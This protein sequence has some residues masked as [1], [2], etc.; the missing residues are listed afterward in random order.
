MDP[1]GSTHCNFLSVSMTDLGR[2][3]QGRRL[4]D[5]AVIDKSLYSMGAGFYTCNQNMK[6]L[7]R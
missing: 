7:L 2:V 5:C 4:E 1:D 6:V 3:M